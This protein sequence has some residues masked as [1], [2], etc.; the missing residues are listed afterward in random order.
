MFRCPIPVETFWW[1]D[2]PSSENVC[3][4]NSSLINVS[5]LKCQQNF[6]TFTTNSKWFIKKFKYYVCEAHFILYKL[7]L[8]FWD[9]LLMFWKFVVE[10]KRLFWIPEMFPKYDILYLMVCLCC[11]FDSTCEDKIATFAFC[12]VDS[13]VGSF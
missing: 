5:C 3:I 2:Y 13:F 6:S 11:L 7:L 10:T 9:T 8:N 4:Y 12:K 1:W